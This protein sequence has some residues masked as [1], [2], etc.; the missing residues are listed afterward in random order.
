MTQSH[1][2]YP[3]KMSAATAL[4]LWLWCFPVLNAAESKLVI[5]TETGQSRDGV[6]VLKLHP[7]PGAIAEV[8]G[9]GFSGRLFRLYQYE[10]EYLRLASSGSK[11]EPAYLLLSNQV[12][13]FPR[14]GFYLD[15]KDKRQA[16]YVDLL[17][18]GPIRGRFGSMDQIFAH[19]LAHIMVRQLAG[20]SEPGGSNQT[21]AI[22]V[23]TDPRQAFQEGFAEHFQIMAIDDPDADPA[24]RSLAFNASW[25][26]MAEDQALRYRCELQSRW[27]LPGPTR[28]G[29]L[30]WFSGTEQVWRYFAVKANAFAHEVELPERMIAARDLYPAYL[31]QNAVPGDLRSPPK[32][33]PVL[34]STEGVVSSFFYQWATRESIQQRYRDAEFYARFGTTSAEVS[35]LENCYL[36]LFHVLFTSKPADSAALIEGYK[37]VFPDESGLIDALV[38][39]VL[40]EQPHQ[41]VPAIWLANRD[42][43]VGTSLFDQYR[44]LPRLHTFDLN[45]ATPIDL[46]S[47]PGMTRSLATL[48][49]KN[50]SYSSLQDL[51]RVP[52]LPQAMLDQFL[53]MSREMDRLKSESAENETVLSIGVILKSYA[54]RALGILV[55]ASAAGALL[56]RR[57]RSVRWMRA[58]A[59]GF[60]ASFLVL[61]LAWLTTGTDACIA[62]LFPIFIL[63]FPAVLWQLAY[64]RKVA[65]AARVLFAWIAAAIPATLLVYPWF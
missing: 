49:L 28:M 19:E 52:G 65:G 34:L 8:L 58:A 45:A 20:E 13:G 10:Q 5:L 18:S 61:T 22:G 11:P 30:V 43:Q 17:K 46:L 62:F 4:L 44:S 31:L 63:G 38:Q 27:F 36:K 12:G 64:Q 32:S 42:F 7:N 3:P 51:R 26:K 16:A 59:N 9:R 24:T 35:P 54:W 29:F 55:L 60:A 47:V 21:H 53:E 41:A 2:L 14:F 56:Y 1:C 40:F 48:I 15:N 57:L 23:R 50:A 6:P 25:R 39:E 37:S 33:V